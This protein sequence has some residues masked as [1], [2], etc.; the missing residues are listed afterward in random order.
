M[1][2]VPKETHAVSVMTHQPLATVAKVRDQKDDCLPRTK[3]EVPKL[4]KEEKNPQKHQATE[5]SSDK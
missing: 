3:F 1:D 5:E 4:T 2:N